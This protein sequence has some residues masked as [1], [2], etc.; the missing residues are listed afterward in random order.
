MTTEFIKCICGRMIKGKSKQNAESNMKK[1][2]ESKEH[3]SDIILLEGKRE[4][5]DINKAI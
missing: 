5:M 1:H 4:F 2:L 3:K